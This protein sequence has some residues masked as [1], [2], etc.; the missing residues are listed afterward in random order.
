MCKHKRLR[1]LLSCYFSIR[2]AYNFPQSNVQI[3]ASPDIYPEKLGFPMQARQ[4]TY[5]NAAVSLGFF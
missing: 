4:V 3:L 2:N 5:P 1:V